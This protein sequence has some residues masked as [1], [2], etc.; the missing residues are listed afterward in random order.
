MRAVTSSDHRP[1]KPETT[2]EAFGTL[3]TLV[4]RAKAGTP[5]GYQLLVLE[6]T[7]L[8]VYPIGKT[9][10]MSIGR[11]DDCDVRLRDP[12]ASRRHAVLHVETL[13]IEDRGSAN[14]TLLG[15]RLLEPM[16][17][18]QIER[19]QAITIGTSLLI[20]NHARSDCRRDRASLPGS[21]VSSEPGASII[22]R[23]PAMKELYA[24][25]ERIAQG[26]INVVILGET[27][28]GKELVTETIHRRSLR[29]EGPLVRINCAALSESL[30]ESEL[31]GHE[32]GAFTGATSSKPGLIEVAH[33]GTV[34]LDEVAELAPTLQ[35]KLLRVLE[36]R[37]VL[38]VGGLHPRAVDVRFVSA[39]NRDLEAEVAR[40]AF[41]SDL[42]FR[43]NGMS[44]FV[45]PLRERPLDIAPL[46]E[47]F[48]DRIADKLGLHLRPRLLPEA[49]KVLSAH[50]WPGNVRELRNAVERA[51][52]LCADSVIG[53]V[54][55]GLLRPSIL[56]E[57]AAAN[58]ATVL[59]KAS[60][61]EPQGQAHGAAGV[62][63]LE[64]KRILEALEMCNG[65]QTRAAKLLGMPR[66][67]LVAKLPLYRIPR[68]RKPNFS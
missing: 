6:S 55:L 63:E 57:R 16:Q 27:G 61:G 36:S 31:F 54:D 59:P 48:V 47:M 5:D 9:G 14:G 52:L 15:G 24:L 7:G 35:A 30:L 37:E 22:V 50:S 8:S 65:N 26:P 10:Q 40:H 19:E 66:R 17:P 33:G 41:R 44:L 34:F 32:R 1:N 43:L 13:A 11:A 21:T 12:L 60:M 45:P 49:I 29:R 4:E 39:T 20:V 38:R 25:V 56:A 42:Y 23:D 64:R 18:V 58:H 2:G 3:T 62:M 67:T 46:A 28:V 68:P 53:P 51:V